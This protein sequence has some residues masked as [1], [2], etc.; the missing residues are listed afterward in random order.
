VRAHRVGTSHC[1][2]S[3]PDGEVCAACLKRTG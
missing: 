2:C 1:G 3:H